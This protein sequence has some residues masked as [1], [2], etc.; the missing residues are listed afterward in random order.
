MTKGA[1]HLLPPW[2]KS[3]S[4][5]LLLLTVGFV[6]LAEVLIYAPS[7]GRFR[8]AYL[9]ERL[10]AA[11]LAI[12]ALETTPDQMIDDELESEL[13]DHVG[14]FSVAL[15]RPEV[16]K[17]LLSQERPPDVDA[18][19]DLAEGR[20]FG[21]IRDSFVTLAGDG[22][23]VL[24][25]VGPSPKNPAVTVE[26]TLSEAALQAEM[27]AFSWRILGLSLLISLFTAALVYLSL[28]WLMVRP[29]SRMA[30]A[31][32]FFREKPEDASRVVKPSDRND[33]IG[34]AQR[35]LASLQEGVRAALGQKNRLAALGS[36]VT[37]INHD[38]R[39]IL[40][41]ASLLGERLSRSDAP[42][43]RHT[44]PNLISAIDRAIDLCEQTLHFSRDGLPNLEIN[45]LSLAEVTNDLAASLP[46]VQDGKV[47]WVSKI[48]SGVLLDGD[49]NQLYR[50]L[51]NLAENA[52]QAGASSITI[53]ARQ[54]QEQVLIDFRDDGPG[55]TERAKANLFQ[56]FAGSTKPGGS[57]LGLAIA[58]E[59]LRAHG[60]DIR[61]LVSS[62]EGTA[63][64]LNLPLRQAPYRALA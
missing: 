49:R 43:V 3:L 5:R 29:L 58:R 31:M 21:L 33:E 60:G 56:P 42:E 23:R 9:E 34:L 8:L 22:K 19:Y 26:V 64:R 57:G 2:A 62:A 20:F 14:A 35:E 24:R 46:E 44:A 6:M 63:F 50:V 13:L 1:S 47:S 51:L 28:H 10:A 4:A 27:A 48:G 39:N 59:I 38:L 40:A 30:A 45:A 16:G 41:T 7:I 37:K 54:E 11:H 32:A 25:I 18:T 15:R 17:L 52:I 55:M 12:L 36:A 61:L 53:E